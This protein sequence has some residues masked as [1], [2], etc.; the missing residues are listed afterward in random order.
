MKVFILIGLLVLAQGTSLAQNSED[1]IPKDA[2]TVFSL[3][4]I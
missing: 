2:V 1:F 3:N 4:N